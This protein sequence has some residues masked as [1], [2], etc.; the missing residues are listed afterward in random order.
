[1]AP[2]GHLPGRLPILLPGPGRTS[3]DSP[4]VEGWSKQPGPPLGPGT[5]SRRGP[6]LGS[7]SAP[8]CRALRTSL[9]HCSVILGGPAGQFQRWG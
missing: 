5:V 3:R 6:G 2:T 4:G 8:P 9:F 7:A 1:M